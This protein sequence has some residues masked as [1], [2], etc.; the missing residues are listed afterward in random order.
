M[1]N[2][3]IFDLVTHANRKG[4]FTAITT[5]GMALSRTFAERL[6]AAG[7]DMIS[8]SL[9]GATKDTAERIMRKSD[10]ERVVAN[11][12]GLQALKRER[13]A[14]KPMIYFNFVSQLANAKEMP[15]FVELSAELEVKHVNLIHLIDGDEAVDKLT[16]LVHYPELLVPNLIR[17]RELGKKLGI[18][19]Y[20]SSAYSELVEQWEQTGPLAERSFVGSQ[21]PEINAEARDPQAAD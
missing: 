8:I 17:A 3:E 9:H 20:I 1:L 11:I 15:D 13:G 7:L 16:N 4:S 21:Q 2:K 19:V 6:L 18:N 5:N 10:F 12:R 14:E